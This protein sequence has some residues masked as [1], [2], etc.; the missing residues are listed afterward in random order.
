MKK[1]IR[2]F[3]KEKAEEFDAKLDNEFNKPFI[4][5]N[6]TGKEV[7]KDKGAFSGFIHPM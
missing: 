1:T 5:R 2:K 4:E 6:N 7:L 3:I